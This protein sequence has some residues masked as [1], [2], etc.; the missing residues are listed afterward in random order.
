MDPQIKKA[1]IACVSEY[2]ANDTDSNG[3]ILDSLLQV[4]DADTSFMDK[5]GGM[6]QIFDNHPYYEELREYLFDLLLMN[7]FSADVAK[8]E[9]DYLES[10]EWEKIEEKTIDRGTE[11]LNL[12]LYIRECMDEDIQPELDDY[13]REFLLVDEDEFQDEYRIYEPVISQPILVDSSFGEIAG[14]ARK[15]DGDLELSELF[16]PLVSYFYEPKP[17]K[18][19][20]EE[21]TIHA[22]NPGLDRSIYQLIINYNL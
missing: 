2:K 9:N 17:K 7:F 22:L 11:L 20:L 6:D 5:V 18:A 10:E 4:F 19:D 15:L 14:A 8:L 1:L 12:L 16:Y 21:F 13:L 3:R